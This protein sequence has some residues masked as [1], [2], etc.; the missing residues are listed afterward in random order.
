[1]KRALLLSG[2][3]LASFPSLASVNGPV[4]YDSRKIADAIWVA[5]GGNRA[6]V[7]HGIL[8]VPVRNAAQ[9]RAV[10][11]RTIRH[12]WTD[13]LAAG[14]PG[15]FLDFLGDRYCPPSADPVGNRHWK[16][17]VHALLHQ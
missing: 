13:W 10:C 16:H 2:L 3:V 1:M 6:R 5:E 14:R 17:N 9:A 4:V 12:A 11:L 15:D 8:A 7:S